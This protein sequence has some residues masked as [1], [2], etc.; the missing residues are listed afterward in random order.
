MGRLNN[1]AEKVEKNLPI[2]ENQENFTASHE[3][4][5]LDSLLALALATNDM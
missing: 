2:S 4:S 5:D 3:E 1:Y